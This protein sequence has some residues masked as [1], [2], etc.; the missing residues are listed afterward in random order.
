MTRWWWFQ[1]YPE[2]KK[3]PASFAYW[4]FCH[5]QN[6]MTSVLKCWA[7]SKKVLHSFCFLYIMAASAVIVVGLSV[8]LPIAQ[9]PVRIPVKMLTVLLRNSSSSLVFS[10]FTV[11][12][13]SFEIRQTAGMS[14]HSHFVVVVQTRL[15]SEIANSSVSRQNSC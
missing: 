15:I 6:S 3:N 4:H 11:G 10:L 13:S 8:K 1:T 2:L 14:Y 7:L 12:H 5:S 9:C